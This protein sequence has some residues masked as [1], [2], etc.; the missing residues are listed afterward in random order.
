MLRRLLAPFFISNDKSLSKSR[1]S[2]YLTTL[3]V[4]LGLHVLGVVVAWY[5][6]FKMHPTD[7]DLKTTISLQI[8]LFATL[9]Q[10]VSLASGILIILLSLK[11]E[12]II[13]QTYE[14]TAKSTQATS[15][16]FPNFVDHIIWIKDHLSPRQMPDATKICVSVSTPLYGIGADLESASEFIDY[17]SSWIEHFEKQETKSNRPQIELTFWSS[18][19]NKST[20]QNAVKESA[21]PT[22]IH[23]LLTKYAEVLQRAHRLHQQYTI[24][25][26]LFKTGESHGRLF[27]VRTPTERAGLT[28][29]FSPLTANAITHRGWGLVGFSFRNHEAFEN[30]YEFNR[31]LQSSSIGVGRPSDHVHDLAKSKEW[32]YRQ[33]GFQPESNPAE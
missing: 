13:S 8:G 27:L 26:S 19:I 31:K 30:V 15:L 11:S 17:I 1:R 16:R 14:L 6:V 23:A 7:E 18:G 4:V 24:D 29:L 22:E 32:L 12:T 10:I 28:I 2:A 9:L 25:L 33:Y 20:F 21:K 5:F 3:A